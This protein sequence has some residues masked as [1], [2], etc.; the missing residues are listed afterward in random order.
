MITFSFRGHGGS[1]GRPTVGDREVPD[2]AA[3][4]RW[5]RSPGHRRVATVGS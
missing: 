3:A 5:A 2:P 1:G 4:L